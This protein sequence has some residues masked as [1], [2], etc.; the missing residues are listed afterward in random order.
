MA[1]LSAD[2]H[3][4]LSEAVE[5]RR[6]MARFDGDELSLRDTAAAHPN[7]LVHVSTARVVSEGFHGLCVLRGTAC[8]AGDLRALPAAPHRG[9]FAD[10]ISGPHPADRQLYVLQSAVHRV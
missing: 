8:P 2:V 1:A 5:R 3:V 7:C 10:R 4:R 6:G 9:R